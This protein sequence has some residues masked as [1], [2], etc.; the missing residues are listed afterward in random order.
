M[1]H[2]QLVA[3]ADERVI[4]E[5]WTKLAITVGAIAAVLLASEILRAIANR[6]LPNREQQRVSFWTTQTVHLLTLAACI[7]VVLL[8]WRDSIGQLGAVGGWIAAGLTVAL[9]RV[10]TSFAGY[11]IILRGNLFN[12][13][14]RIT[15][16]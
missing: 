13:G 4:P 10:V 15:I 14:D 9:Q 16:G 8:V 6:V 1:F 2:K 11:L 12:V 5:F 7:A 3:S